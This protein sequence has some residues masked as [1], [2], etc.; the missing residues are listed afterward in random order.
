[1]SDVVTTAESVSVAQQAGIALELI[2]DQKPELFVNLVGQPV[3]AL[4]TPEEQ[5]TARPWPLR[6]ERVKAWI[7]ELVWQR[8]DIVLGERDIDRI[9][10]VLIGKAWKDQ[11]TNIALTEAVDQDPLLD[12]LIVFMQQNAA[13]DGSSTKLL[14]ELSKAAMEAGLDTRDR[15][16]P[17]GAPQLSRRIRELKDLLRAAYIASE[18]G[19]RG[20]GVRFVKLTRLKA[21]DDGPK[22]PPQSPSIDKSHHPDALRRNDDA[23]GEY[24]DQLFA[25]LNSIPRKPK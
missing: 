8:Q 25:K 6:S 13:F 20:S 23:D 11:R 7:A 4:P 16:W 9:I 14:A 10:T 1:M 2:L 19:R 21:A 24:R 22:S 3:I 12:A 18:T 5:P 17:S 15:L